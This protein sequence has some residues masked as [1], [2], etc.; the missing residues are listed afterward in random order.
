MKLGRVTNVDPYEAL[1][2]MRLRRSV[3][4]KLKAYQEFYKGTYGDEAS[5][6]ELIEGIVRQFLDEDKEFRQHLKKIEDT[7]GASA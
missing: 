4:A 5:L 7:Q 6:N 1:G 2:N 3:K